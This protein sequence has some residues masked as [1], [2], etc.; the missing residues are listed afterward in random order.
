MTR[1]LNRASDLKKRHFSLGN[2][3][4]RQPMAMF[5]EESPPPQPMRW[6]RWRNGL[7][8]WMQK[9]TGATQ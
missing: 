9:T 8:R 5:K 2:Q 6:E 3:K 7:K 1:L 4:P